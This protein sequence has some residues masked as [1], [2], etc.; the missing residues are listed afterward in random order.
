MM[1]DRNL[2]R[3]Y[4]ILTQCRIHTSQYDSLNMVVHCVVTWGEEYE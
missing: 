4:L 3:K 2:D 1:I